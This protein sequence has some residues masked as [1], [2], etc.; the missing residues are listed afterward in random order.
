MIMDVMMKEGI[1][2]LLVAQQ[3]VQSS[4]VTPG[5]DVE[6]V[7]RSFIILP[8]GSTYAAAQAACA[9]M[10]YRLG[11]IKCEDDNAKVWQAM[12]AAGTTGGAAWVGAEDL[13]EE[14]TFRW[15][16]DGVAF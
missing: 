1:L 9:S 11:S 8:I 4:P 7:N 5:P 15:L 13:A 14:G 12:V 2:L 3:R 16:D 6:V 10:G